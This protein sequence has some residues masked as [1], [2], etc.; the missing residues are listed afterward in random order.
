METK[1]QF[2]IQFN[3]MHTNFWSDSP[4]NFLM[5]NFFQVRTMT[6]HIKFRQQHCTLRR[7]KNLTSGRIQNRNL[8][9]CRRTRWPLCHAAI[10]FYFRLLPREQWAFA[11][12]C[13]HCDLVAN[14]L[15]PGSTLFLL[16]V[17]IYKLL[18]HT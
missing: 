17:I 18:R 8:L 11:F 13:G 1:Y 10:W 16:A 9:F 5:Y 2:D 4:N 15:V 7:P 6:M 3:N 14:I 12:Y